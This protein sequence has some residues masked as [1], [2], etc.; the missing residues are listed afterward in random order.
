MGAAALS[1][2]LKTCIEKRQKL[3]TQLDKVEQEIQSVLHT[4][5]LCMEAHSM[6]ELLHAPSS[7]RGGLSLTKRREMALIQWAQ[8]NNSNLV[9]K[10]AK[11]ALMAGGLLPPGE[12][13]RWIIYGRI[14]NMECWEKV[15]PGVYH[16]MELPND[17]IPNIDTK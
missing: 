1:E 4:L 13:A 12:S 10:E 16:L 14:S 7:E 8:K 2:H 9:V 11:R 5:K 17:T 6:P 15:K 3:R